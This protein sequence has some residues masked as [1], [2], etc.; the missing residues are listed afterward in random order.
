MMNENDH[1]IHGLIMFIAFGVIFPASMILFYF[2]ALCKISKHKRKIS[3]YV[4]FILTFIMCIIGIIAEIIVLDGS[5]FNT[6]HSIS[7]IILLCVIFISMIVFFVMRKHKFGLKKWCDFIICFMFQIWS[8]YEML[9]GLLV[10]EN[11][12]NNSKYYIYGLLLWFGII[13]II[14]VIFSIYIYL[15]QSITAMIIVKGSEMVND[16]ES[17][18]DGE[19]EQLNEQQAESSHIIND[20]IVSSDNETNTNDKHKYKPIVS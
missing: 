2:G 15:T 5:Y 20:N 3:H 1:L 19:M 11:K 13:I 12:N 14:F 9:S 10:G 8:L 4:G 17:D 16:I 18:D 6:S 7:G